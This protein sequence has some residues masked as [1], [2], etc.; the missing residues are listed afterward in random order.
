MAD[1]GSERRIRVLAL[2][3]RPRTAAVR[4]SVGVPAGVSIRRWAGD[5]ARGRQTRRYD[6]GALVRAMDPGPSG[7]AMKAPRATYRLQ[8]RREFG[9]A[10]AAA[11]TGYLRRLGVSHVYASP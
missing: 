9:F 8:F 2:R 5:L 11:I 3:R 6:A 7:R 4:Q 1:R 10:D